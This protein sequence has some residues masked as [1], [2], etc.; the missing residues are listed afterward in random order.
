LGP[1]PVRATPGEGILT[2][3]EIIAEKAKQFNAKSLAKSLAQ[4]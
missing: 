2:F 1:A 4:F 3:L